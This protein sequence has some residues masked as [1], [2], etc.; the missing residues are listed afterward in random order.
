MTA[1]RTFTHHHHVL[2]LH[3]VLLAAGTAR[4]AVD[5]AAKGHPHR[6]KAADGFGQLVVQLAAIAAHL[7]YQLTQAQLQAVDDGVFDQGN[8]Q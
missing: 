3:P 7:A 5:N 4:L 8:H 2:A 6:R 1:Y